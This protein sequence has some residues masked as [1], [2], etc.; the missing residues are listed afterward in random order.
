MHN[1]LRKLFINHL[2]E[3]ISYLRVEG[4]EVILVVG[5]NKNSIDGRLNKALYQ[6]GL[7]EVLDSLAIIH[8]LP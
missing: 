6:V 8:E 2:V 4:Y 1:Y 5:I 7:I 3:F